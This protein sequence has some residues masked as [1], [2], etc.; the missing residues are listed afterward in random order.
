[1]NDAVPSVVAID[2]GTHKVSV[3]IAKIHAPDHIEVVGMASARNQGMKR[4]K[5]T[6]LDK[7][8]ASIKQ[9]VSDVEDMTECRIHSAWVSIPSADLKSFYAQGQAYITNSERIVTTSEVVSVLEDAKKNKVAQETELYLTS[10]V[11]LGFQLDDSE[12]WVTHP[13]GLGASKVSGHYQLMMMPINE[14]QNFDR[15]M[16]SA[17][18]RVEKTILCSLATAEASLLQDEK[19]YGVCLIDIGAGTTNVAVYLEGHLVFA[20]TYAAGGDSVTHDIA[21]VLQTTT[22]EAERIK[23]LYGC[24]DLQVVKPDHMVQVKG[25]EGPQTISRIELSEIIIARYEEILHTVKQDLIQNGAMSG[26]YHGVVLTGA[27]SQIEGVVS[28][29]RRLFGVS[30]HLGNLPTSVIAINDLLPALKRP[31]Y[32]TAIGLLLYSQKEP[33]DAIDI[34]P[35]AGEKTFVRRLKNG[36]DRFQAQLKAIF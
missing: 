13:V 35:D 5:I 24:V 11:P 19:D 2:I 28:F 6:S 29:S 4:G 9:A 32:A 18:I 22:E 23:L 17:N 10:A 30:A 25:I 20:K 1:M 21:A 27:A 36:W 31:Q 33:S 3:L 12:Q 16:K 34:Q 26:L 8:I 15:A 7:M 14:M